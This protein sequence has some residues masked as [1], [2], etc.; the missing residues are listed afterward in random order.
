M[1]IGRRIEA[2]IDRRIVNPYIYGFAALLIMNG[3]ALCALACGYLPASRER[4]ATIIVTTICAA[5]LWR[6]RDRIQGV[7][8]RLHPMDVYQIV[9]WA[10]IV[11]T[12]ALV[13]TAR[14]LFW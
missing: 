7:W 8:K 9:A 5:A 10:P 2:A 3:F 13:L 6:N 12:L 1:G 14:I 4:I 11:V